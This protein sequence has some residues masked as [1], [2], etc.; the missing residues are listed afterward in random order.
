MHPHRVAMTTSSSK[1]GKFDCLSIYNRTI[2][3]CGVFHLSFF[4]KV[5]DECAS[6]TFFSTFFQMTIK[7]SSLHD[8]MFPVSVFVLGVRPYSPEM[9]QDLFF[10][11]CTFLLLLLFFLV[12]CVQKHPVSNH[13]LFYFLRVLLIAVYSIV[14]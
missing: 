5:C 11:S 8:L 9:P 4:R 7:A 10:Y 6:S 3:Y 12:F 2:R 14:A 13:M 1:F